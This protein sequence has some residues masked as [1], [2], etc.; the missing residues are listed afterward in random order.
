[1]TTRAETAARRAAL[2]RIVEGNAPVTVRQVFYIAVTGG[3]IE[4]TERGYRRIIDDLTL[5][6]RGGTIPYDLIADGS[7]A[8]IGAT[9]DREDLDLDDLIAAHLR[10]A[11]DDP[12][13][14]PWAETRIRPAVVCESR[15]IAGVIAAVCER[16]QI[17]LW[18]LGGSPSLSFTADLAADNP[19]VIAYVGDLDASGEQIRWTL[20]DHLSE[21]GCDA[22]VEHL[23]VTDEQVA[24]M[25]L[26][27]RPGKASNHAKATGRYTAVEAEAIPSPTMRRIVADWVSGLQPVGWETRWQA[28]TD[29][30]RETVE[31]WAAGHG[32][33][34]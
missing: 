22:A 11:A 25:G 24:S 7:R 30:A 1:M 34:L 8:R 27:E 20:G 23:A 16:W 3:L 6:R 14:S 9:A 17:G 13:I 5:L 15:S 10:A 18:P 21:H 32:V 26:P 19:T 29:Q 12:G 4:K 28:R 31:D 2:T 33:A